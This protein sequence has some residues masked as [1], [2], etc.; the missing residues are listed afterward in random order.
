MQQDLYTGSEMKRRVRNNEKPR[1]RIGGV[2]RARVANGL[3]EPLDRID[4]PEGKEIGIVI[5]EPLAPCDIKAFRRA[6]GSWKG[7]VDADKLSR[8]IYD[9]RRWFRQLDRFKSALTKKR[10]RRVLTPRRAIS[11]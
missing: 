10:G 1:T 7:N 9:V 6:A 5:L 3:L 11:D 4:L 2:I 8:D